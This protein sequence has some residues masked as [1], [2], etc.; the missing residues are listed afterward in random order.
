MGRGHSHGRNELFLSGIGRN[1]PSPNLSQPPHTRQSDIRRGRGNVAQGF[2]FRSSG[3]TSASHFQ[4]GGWAGDS[5]SIVRPRGN[6]SGREAA[7]ADFSSWRT[8]PSN[9]PRLA[10]HA[11]LLKVLRHESVPRRPRLHRFGAA[12]AA[13]KWPGPPVPP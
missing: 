11:L 3:R 12:L 13:P 2:S 5:W 1:S 6:E 7:R 4:V 8:D 9:A 10:L